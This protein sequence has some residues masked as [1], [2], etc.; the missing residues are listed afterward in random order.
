MNARSR[1]EAA[2]SDPIRCSEPHLDVPA[3]EFAEILQLASSLCDTAGAALIFTNDIGRW[4]AADID[5]NLIPVSPVLN[6]LNGY[7]LQQAEIFIVRDLLKD[8]R[9]AAADATTSAGALRF[10]AG[11]PLRTR[12]GLVFGSLCVMDTKR[13][14]LGAAQEKA[15]RLLARQ[16]VRQAETSQRI[17]GVTQN[18]A[19]CEA[20]TTEY[21]QMQERMLSQMARLTALRAIDVSIL[22]GANV[23]QTLQLVLDQILAL[24]QA[25]ASA[26]LILDNLTQTLDCAAARGLKKIGCMLPPIRVGRGLVG[27]AIMEGDPTPHWNME[28]DDEDCERTE[29]M[30]T[31]GFTDYYAVPLIARGAYKGV[32]EVFHRVPLPITPEWID[33]LMA[34][35]GQAAIA[36]DNEALFRGLQQSN[37]ELAQAYD[38]TIEG[39]SAALDLRDKETDGHS[40][41]VTEMALNLARALGVS[42][43]ELVNMRRGA[44]LHDIGKMGVPDSILLKPGPLTD[45]EWIIMRQHPVFAYE[46]LSQI[47]FLRPA[48]DIP[49]YHHEKWDGSGYPH[50]LKE[51]Q[52]PLAARIFAVVDIWDALCSDR[53]YRRGWPKEKVQRHLRSLAGTHLDPDIVNTFLSFAGA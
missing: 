52:I 29:I 32:I 30:Q 38:T 12:N 33:F 50:G 20:E 26:I 10:Y 44:L 14:T 47:A 2:D 40:R 49:Y 43:E 13:R 36:I 46:M 25:D 22:S 16:A 17:A 31:E 6:M 35:A 37:Q 7:T 15:L 1:N 9:F 41:R 11:I 27:R 45:D 3:Q 8:R 5:G 42:E 53:P 34:L 48:L 24:L 51:R 23:K 28:A 19:D 4:A 21:G 39:W 18:L